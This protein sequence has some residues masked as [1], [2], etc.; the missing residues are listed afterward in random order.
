MKQHNS[1]DRPSQSRIPLVVVEGRRMLRTSARRASAVAGR[2]AKRGRRIVDRTV[3]QTEQITRRNPWIGLGA[4]AC[5]GL[6]VGV[7][8][9]WL[10]RR[11]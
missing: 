9:T 10:I 1:S 3:R 2:V 7:L 6:F 8:T 5:T 4:A 11:R